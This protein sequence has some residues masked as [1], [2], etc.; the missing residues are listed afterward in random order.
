MSFCA[1]LRWRI[2]LTCIGTWGGRAADEP[3]G[4]LGGDHG[5][6]RFYSVSS[7]G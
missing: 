3:H 7:A 2:K 5:V 1:K 4:D 6:Q